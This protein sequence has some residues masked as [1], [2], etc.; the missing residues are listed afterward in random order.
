M[1]LRF[2][3]GHEVLDTFSTARRDIGVE[4]ADASPLAYL[5]ALGDGAPPEAALSFCA[6]LLPRREAVWWGCRALRALGH[7]GPEGEPAGPLS[8]AERWVERPDDASRRAA[9]ALGID[10][11]LEQPTPWMALAAGW[12][13]GSMALG[14][15][16]VPVQ[17]HLTAR[18]VRAGLLLGLAA[19]S[20]LRRHEAG[21]RLVG[22]GRRIASGEEVL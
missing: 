16:A 5:D 17:S 3:T 12:A 11:D 13:G 2:G 15:Y 14:A 18:A 7:P 9:L 8:A 22:L 20:P 1:R 21:A 10:S 6:Y 4:R 19:L